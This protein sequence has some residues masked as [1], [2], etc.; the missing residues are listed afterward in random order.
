MYL[1]SVVARGLSVG[2]GGG[3]GAVNLY[4]AGSSI[5]VVGG[6]TATV[7]SGGTVYYNAGTFL[8][9]GMLRVNDAGH[10]YL[11]SGGDKTLR[12]AALSING[13]GQIDLADNDTIVDYTGIS[14]ISIIGMYIQSGSAGNWNGSGLTSSRAA[15]SPNPGDAGKTA[16]GLA[17]AAALGISTF[18]GIP[19]DATT[20]LVKYTYLGDANLDGQVDISDLGKLATNW[21]AGVSNPLGPSLNQ[22]LASLSLP[23]SS[24]PEPAAPA[25][26]L[27]GGLVSV[28]RRRGPSKG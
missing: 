5:T 19:V 14:P 10:V 21:Q 2:D 27:V 13:G 25:L 26:L 28:R 4:G 23:G 20:I 6:G 22:A 18:D 1:R 9:T 17:E 8:V 16:L 12:A 15:S 3:R 7:G 11:S 24:V